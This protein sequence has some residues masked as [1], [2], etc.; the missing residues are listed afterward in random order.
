MFHLLVCLMCA[1]FM[2]GV[3]RGQKRPLDLIRSP[4]IGV[5]DGCALLCGY[6]KLNLGPL[7]EHVI[8]T[9]EPS[10]QPTRKILKNQIV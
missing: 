2:P 6:W 7:E 4:G 9:A 1:M 3:V 8:L 5:I 10:F